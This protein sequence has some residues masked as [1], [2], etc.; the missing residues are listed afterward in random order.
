[1]GTTKSTTSASRITELQALLAS[2]QAEIAGLTQSESSVNSEAVA[3]LTADEWMRIRLNLVVH[4]KNNKPQLAADRKSYALVKGAARTDYMF[5]KGFESTLRSR[6]RKGLPVQL[7]TEIAEKSGKSQLMYAV[8][9]IERLIAGGFV[10]ADRF[11]KPSKK[12][13]K[14]T[15]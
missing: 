9:T 14:S 11:A 1:M 8:E 15:K 7:G 3:S 2:V 10:K 13:R 5:A 4:D 12:A 6:A